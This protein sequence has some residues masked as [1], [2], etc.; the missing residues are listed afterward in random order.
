MFAP[1]TQK[2]EVGVV[3][4][5]EVSA[6]ESSVSK[7]ED[8]SHSFLGLMQ[9]CRFMDNRVAFTPAEMRALHVLLHDNTTSERRE[10]FE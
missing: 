6:A 9:V 4:G 10:F 1:S 7:Q 3:V 2:D 5:I 8:E